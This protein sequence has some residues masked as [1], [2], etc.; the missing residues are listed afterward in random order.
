MFVDESRVALRL[1]HPNVIHSY[2]ASANAGQYYLAMEFL[3]GKTL[4]EILGKGGRRRMPLHLHLW[5][6]AQVLKG[7][8]YA[9][10]LTDFDVLLSASFTA[11]S[12][13]RTCSSPATAR[14]SCSTSGS[15]SSSELSPKRTRN[16]QR[17][18]RVRLTRTVPWPDRRRARRCVFDGGHAVGGDCR[19]PPGGG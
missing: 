7:L 14:S 6:L 2:E 19:L 12:R 11:M 5:I 9:H 3:E 13:R 15:P 18:S 16:A 1:N 17:Q 4:D 10:E 8:R